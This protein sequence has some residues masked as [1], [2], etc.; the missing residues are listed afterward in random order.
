MLYVKSVSCLRAWSKARDFA[1]L[2]KKLLMDGSVAFFAIVVAVTAA[3]V[4]KLKL[5]KKL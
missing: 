5:L 2:R 3:G 4:W 1:R